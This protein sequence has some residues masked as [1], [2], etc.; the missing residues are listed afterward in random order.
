MGFRGQV[1]QN[2][3][4][5]KPIGGELGL[6][7]SPST[8]RYQSL[9]TFSVY[10]G[11][12][13]FALGSWEPTRSSVGSLHGH[14]LSH[15]WRPFFTGL[16]PPS[17]LPRSCVPMAPSSKSSCQADLVAVGMPCLRTEL[18]IGTLAQRRRA[19]RRRLRAFCARLTAV[20]VAMAVGLKMAYVRRYASADSRWPLG[21]VPRPGTGLSD[22]RPVRRCGRLR[23]G[24]P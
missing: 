12:S 3:G 9:A 4:G 18:D 6:V 20:L 22:L 24:I 11:G 1:S 8:W 5:R 14:S 2:K 21:A 17:A 16:R 15:L 7:H 13:A 23:G 19:T 10:I